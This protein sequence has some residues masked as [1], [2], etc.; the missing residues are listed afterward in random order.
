MKRK[1]IYIR[2]PFIVPVYD[3]QK[4][5]MFGTTDANC[6]NDE[7]A[8]GFDYY[9]TTDLESFEGPFEAFRPPKD[10]G[11]DRNFWAPEVHYYKGRYYM[12]ASFIAD[13]K[14]RGTHILSSNK[15]SGPFT[16]WSTGPVTPRDWMCLDG[17]M[18]VDGDAQPWLV[19]C[20][21][22]VQVYDGEIWAVKLS[23]DLK[24]VVGESTLLFKASDAPWTKSIKVKDGREC[25]V[26]DGPYLHRTSKGELIML[27]SSFI[28]NH[29]Y[30]IGV[31]HSE[32]GNILGPWINEETPLFSNDGGHGM[33]FTAFN[34]SLML[35]L[36]APNARGMERPVFIKVKEIDGALSLC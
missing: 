20:H 22:W 36:H 32:T 5:Y 2:D 30:A 26:T 8:T 7:K 17:T 18:F 16:P 15:V 33:L 19:F 13:G 14:N 4:Y 28:E 12:F 6:W 31:A 10:F 25:F 3:E 23:I 1:E 21:E 9:T 11:W 27:W 34:G 35:A 29:N 24:S